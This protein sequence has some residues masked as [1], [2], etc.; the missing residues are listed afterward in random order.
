MP[1]LRRT[2]LVRSGFACGWKR[3]SS[4]WIERG[5]CR[6]CCGGRR[7]L[8]CRGL[9]SFFCYRFRGLLGRRGFLGYNS[10][11]LRRSGFLG[12]CC[13]LGCCLGCRSGLFCCCLYGCCLLGCSLCGSGLGCW[14]LDCNCLFG[15]C[16]FLGWCSFLC[17]RDSS[18]FG[19]SRY[20]FR[21]RSLLGGRGSFLC[22]RSLHGC[23]FLCSGLSSR[24]FFGWCRFHGSRFL[25]GNSLF[26]GWFFCSCHYFL[27]DLFTKSTCCRLVGIKRCMV[28]GQCPAPC[29]RERKHLLARGG[30]W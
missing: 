29:T 12:R 19:R 23:R 20:F 16:G 30:E 9:C 17:W 26:C 28:L 15:G 5:L 25:C 2:S 27:L 18:L 13:L 14:S 6:R 21:R 4:L 11:L 10:C 24:Y 8:R 3:P 22:W 7:R 1:G